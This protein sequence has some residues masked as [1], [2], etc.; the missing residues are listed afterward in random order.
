MFILKNLRKSNNIKAKIVLLLH[1]YP[2]LIKH[3][4]NNDSTILDNINFSIKE[5]Y[6][7][8]IKLFF[9]A[10]HD[11]HTWTHFSSNLTMHY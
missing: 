4:N 6:N 9:S 11:Q 1:F 3:K 8:L 2:I 7:Y 5:Y 10:C